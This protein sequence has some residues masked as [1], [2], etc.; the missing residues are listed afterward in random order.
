MSASSKDIRRRIKSATNIQ[1][2]TKAME[3]VAATKMRRA[4]DKAVTGRVYAEKAFLLLQHLSPTLDPKLH[5]LL[6]KKNTGRQ[7]VVL[8]MTDKGLVGGQNTNLVRKMQDFI[9]DQEAQGRETDVIAIGKKAHDF[10]E[11]RDLKIIESY[12]FEDDIN[13]AFVSPISSRA[14]KEYT[15]GPYDKIIMSYTNFISTLSQKPFIRGILPLTYEKIEDLGD[16]SD[17]E[18]KGL[19]IAREEETKETIDYIFEPSTQKV[20]NDLLPRFVETLV[21]HNLLEA[22]ASEHSARMVAMKNASENAGELIDDLTLTYNR[23]RQ[24]GITKEL[25]E[26]SAGTIQE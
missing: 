14:M 26:I 10:A 1:Q 6:K 25:A 13:T 21:Y 17:E 20:L 22:N 24:E 16:L 2:I 11:K 5:S 15:D 18:A 9:K 23:L 8:I 19:K 4:Q 3:T 7:L 12:P